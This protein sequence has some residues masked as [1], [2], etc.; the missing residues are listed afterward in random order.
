MTG[1]RSLSLHATRGGFAAIGEV[2]VVLVGLLDFVA[3][4]GGEQVEEQSA[5]DGKMEAR[6]DA[7]SD[8]IRSLLDRFA[9]QPFDPA[10][11]GRLDEALGAGPGEESIGVQLEEQPSP[12]PSLRGG[13]VPEEFPRVPPA[14]Q[15]TSD[16]FVDLVGDGDQQP[17]LGP[18]VVKQHPVAGAD[19]RRDLAQALVGDP[20]LERLVHRRFKQ[21]LP[22]LRRRHT[23]LYRLV[24]VP[25]DTGEER[26]VSRLEVS[27]EG[28]VSAPAATV[29][30]YIA[31]M[32]D[33]HPRFLPEAFSGFEVES[34]GVGS[35]T[36][37]RF[38]LT[39]GGRTRDYRSEVD[40]PEPGRVLRETD[41]TSS[42]VTT[43]TVRPKEPGCQV[44]ISTTWEGAGGVGGF[45]ER[46]FAPRV[47]QRIYAD[48]LTRLDAY[49]RERADG[50][51]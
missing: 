26:G 13:E 35:G 1:G 33:H 44:R 3:F 8:L 46:L 9:G 22:G 25:A 34:G 42:A 39:A 41:T 51:P 21:T 20:A 23:R 50:A 47:M 2:Q 28:Q 30:G 16:G 48:E 37:I 7:S 36:V 5:G 31:D 11:H 24:H 45:F 27:A 10:V 17:F 43:F 49:A 12:R 6:L 38:K 29:Y 14:V 40:E 4:L 18:E 15:R 19:G 32:R